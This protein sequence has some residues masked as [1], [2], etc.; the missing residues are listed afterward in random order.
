MIRLRTREQQFLL[1]NL[2]ST[3]RST[4]LWSRRSGY[5]DFRLPDVLT[6]RSGTCV[7]Q[8][9]VPPQWGYVPLSESW[10]SQLV[11]RIA[12]ERDSFL[13]SLVVNCAN[14]NRFSLMLSFLS[15]LF[16]SS[17]HPWA[18]SPSR[19]PR[20][21]IIYQSSSTHPHPT[22]CRFPPPPTTT[23]RIRPWLVPKSRLYPQSDLL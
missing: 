8:Q 2:H 5:P 14:L 11:L 21:Y 1:S 17:S 13:S 23:C 4:L 16:F 10:V 7:S 12:V 9:S 3:H 15:N 22:P 20:S 6:R 19:L 18:F